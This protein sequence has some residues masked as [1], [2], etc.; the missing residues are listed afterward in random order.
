MVNNKCWKD[1]LDYNCELIVTYEA[2]SEQQIKNGLVRIAY[3]GSGGD[4]G[5]TV[6]ICSEAEGKQYAIHRGWEE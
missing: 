2:L 6:K 1:W 4:F 5:E 3:Y